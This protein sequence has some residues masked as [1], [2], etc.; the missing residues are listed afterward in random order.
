MRGLRTAKLNRAVESTASAFSTLVVAPPRRAVSPSRG[1]PGVRGVAAA[2]RERARREAIEAAAATAM[3]VVDCGSGGTRVSCFALDSVDGLVHRVT[4]TKVSTLHVALIAAEGGDGAAIENW[5]EH[6]LR[7]VDGALQ[8]DAVRCPVYIGAT[9]GLRG[10]IASGAVSSATLARFERAAVAAFAARSIHLT[11][12]TPMSGDEEATLELAAAR[13]CTAHCIEAVAETGACSPGPRAFKPPRAAADFA[14]P[15]PERAVAGALK[16]ATAQ[17]QLGLLS[18]GGM[19]AQVV[20]C[21]EGEG[22]DVRGEARAFVTSFATELIPRAN[23]PMLAARSGGAALDI[24]ARYA[25]FLQRTVALPDPRAAPLKG[26]FVAIEMFGSVGERVG[27]GISRCGAVSAREA[28][29]AIAA[30]LEQWKER[31]ARASDADAAAWDWHCT[32]SSP[33]QSSSLIR[34]LLRALPPAHARLARLFF[35]LFSLFVLRI[36]ARPRVLTHAPLHDSLLHHPPP[37]PNPKP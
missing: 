14:H 16:R 27:L 28:S 18:M 12:A 32:L 20:H 7:A 37:N 5:V 34:L 19:S 35:C 21:G 2:K 25:D 6:V 3:T 11:L 15:R 23:D 8:S 24:V 9:A 4:V 33:S 29:D 26:A 17:R 22:D 36:D 1:S 10:Y 30:H 13:Y 31:V